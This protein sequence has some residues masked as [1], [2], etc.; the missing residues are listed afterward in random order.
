M[1]SITEVCYCL[2]SLFVVERFSAHI[3]AIEHAL[4]F[5]VILVFLLLLR[6]FAV[7]DVGRK[8]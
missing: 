7:V 6:L 4:R 8:Q 1:L 2:F 5:F 3:I